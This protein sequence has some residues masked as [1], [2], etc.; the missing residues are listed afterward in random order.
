MLVATWGVVV[1]G[2]SIPLQFQ[3]IKTQILRPVLSFW[4]SL[5]LGLVAP[6]ETGSVRPACALRISV[7]GSTQES[8][9]DVEDEDQE[10]G[11]EKKDLEQDTCHLP[12]ACCLRHPA[13]RDRIVRNGDINGSRSPNYH[14]LG[15]RGFVQKGRGHMYQEVSRI[16]YAAL[17]ICESLPFMFLVTGHCNCWKYMSDTA[18]TC[19]SPFLRVAIGVDT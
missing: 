9:E 11:H 10:E 4:V 1:S 2:T 12:P 3:P 17:K 13:L 5:L 14:R 15:R 18:Q 16:R 7:D 8:Q 19:S 6:A